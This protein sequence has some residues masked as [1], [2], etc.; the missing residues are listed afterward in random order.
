MSE[1]F[2]QWVNYYI[3]LAL[4]ITLG[5]VYSYWRRREKLLQKHG[6]LIKE[7]QLKERKLNELNILQED[8]NLRLEASQEKLEKVNFTN[9]K[10]LS[11]MAHD[12]K[13]PLKFMVNLASLMKS[14]YEILSKDERQENLEI[15]STTGNKVFDLVQNM[16]QWTK[17]QSESIKMKKDPVHLKSLVQEKIELFNSGAKAKD[18][19]LINDLSEDIY[20]WGDVNMLGLVFQNLISN[21]IKF[22]RSKGSVRIYTT[23]S[24]E[25]VVEIAVED[26]G[27]GMSVLDVERLL[28]RNVHHTTSGTSEEPGSGL[29]MMVAQEMIARHDSRIFVESA[30]GKGSKFTFVLQLIN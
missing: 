12:V 14:N 5:V 18:I 3:L 6:E 8:K 28:D 7:L 15:I 21:S 10:L 17:M 13:G 25:E 27:I 23:Y 20:I 30:I 29:G 24:L 2:S 22:T 1:F 19:D 26:T 16:L 9:N 4:I 11:I